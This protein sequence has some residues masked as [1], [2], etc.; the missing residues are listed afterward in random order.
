MFFG[1]RDVAPQGRQTECGGGRRVPRL[2]EGAGREDRRTG[3]PAA[4]YSRLRGKWR[5]ESGRKNSMTDKPGDENDGYVTKEM[6]TT[7][8]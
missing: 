8:S 7:R 6:T 2:G 4:D 5:D 1:H 3:I